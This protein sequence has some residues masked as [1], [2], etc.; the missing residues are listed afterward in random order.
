VTGTAAIRGHGGGPLGLWL[1]A[2]FLGVVVMIAAATQLSSHACG[3]SIGNDPAGVVFSIVAGA[4]MLAA[5]GVGCWRAAWLV[6]RNGR[7]GWVG[8]LL[9]AL[10]LLAAAAV[11]VDLI[12]NSTAIVGVLVL[13]A[14]IAGFAVTITAFLWLLT[15]LPGR[16]A[17]DEVG[18]ELPAYYFG[19]AL[20][21]YPLVYLVADTINYGCFT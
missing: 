5:F 10:L 4:V 15:I 17:L 6:R 14:L 1:A 20:F 9:I 21:V 11:V 7:L 2:P 19:F 12:T 18:A 8:R 3:T 16:P 13:A